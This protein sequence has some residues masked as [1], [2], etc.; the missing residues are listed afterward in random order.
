M[1]VFLCALAALLVL[2]QISF[3][4]S[5]VRTGETLTVATDQSVAGDFYGVGGTTAISG[6]IEEDLLLLA[7]AVKMNGTVGA[8]M[9][10]V[11]GTV[12]VDGKISDDVR[13]AGGTVTIAGEV[14]GDLVVFASELKVLSTASIGGDILFFGGR[15]EVAGIVGKDVLGTSE[16]IRIDGTVN[17][18]L[19]V[20]TQALTIGDRAI[21]EGDVSYTSSRELVRAQEAVIKGKIVRS[22]VVGATEVDY[23]AIVIGF[24]VWLFAA[25][26][27]H[28]IFRSAT[29]RVVMKIMS[30]PL[31][32][33]AIGFAV[34]FL[35]PL[36]ASTLI[37]STLGS[38]IGVALLFVY[39]ALLSLS[40]PIIGIVAGAY[41]QKLFGRSP[42]TSALMVSVGVAL[43]SL[44]LY[45][46][47]VG[48]FI[49]LSIL[50]LVLGASAEIIYRLVRG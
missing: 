10:V 44:C 1:K 41:T 27:M 48:L 6:Q 2:P 21:I 16:V 40:I 32:S 8:D 24:L 45:V 37:L 20:T 5:V 17:G 34:L 50:L 22:D 4:A 19:D 13:V 3:A 46:P 35:T 28:L 18:R 26:L 31:R 14:S 29:D 11:G 38:I 43:M 23:R 47:V 39:F 49:V 9:F 25:L 36:I 12:D 33:S 42:S 15:A 30:E 7:G